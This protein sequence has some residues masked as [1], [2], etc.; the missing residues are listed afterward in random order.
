[1]SVP[2]EHKRK[3]GTKKKHRN[4]KRQKKRDK[5]ALFDTEIKGEGKKWECLYSNSYVGDITECELCGK[6]L[7]FTSNQFL[8]CPNEK[9]G[10]IYKNILDQTAE[11][12]YYGASGDRSV[13]PTRCGMPINP[14]LLESSYGCTVRCGPRSSWEMRKIRRLLFVVLKITQ[15]LNIG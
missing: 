12:R 13:N 3:M 8:S 10:V 2:T 6:I 7:R 4:I 5:W 11:W 9:C 14:L 15:R 1:M